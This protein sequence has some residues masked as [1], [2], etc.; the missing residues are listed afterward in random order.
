MPRQRS[1]L[2]QFEGM[3]ARQQNSQTNSVI[4]DR[5]ANGGGSAVSYMPEIAEILA[6]GLMR[7]QARKSSGKSRETGESSL[8]FSGGKSGHQAPVNGRTTDG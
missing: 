3:N 2:L 8:D 6:A 4:A 5:Y 7:V 1:N